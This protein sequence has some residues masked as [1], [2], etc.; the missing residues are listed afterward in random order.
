MRARLHSDERGI[1]LVMA[2]GILIV[3]SISTMAMLEY[4]TANARTA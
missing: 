3:L 4:T 1:A 2:L